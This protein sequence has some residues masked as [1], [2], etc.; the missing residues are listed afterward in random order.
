[1]G[2]PQ[3]DIKRGRSTTHLPDSARGSIKRHLLPLYGSSHKACDWDD[4]VA[5]L[6][7]LCIHVLVATL[8][9]QR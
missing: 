2:A 1:M 5:A 9:F 8:W 4:K 7:M 6:A 3:S